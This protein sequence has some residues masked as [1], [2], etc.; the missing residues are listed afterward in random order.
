[1]RINIA[2]PLLDDEE[3][4]AVSRV[5]STGMIA[6]GPE[7][8]KFE[9]EFASYVGTKYACAVNNGTSALCLALSAAGISPGDEV[10]TTPFTFV[11][12]A[13]SILSCGAIPVFADIDEKTYNLCPKSVERLISE[14]TKAVMP[15]HLYGL[16]A[17]MNAFREIARS[18]GI[19]IIGD[20]AQAHGARIG[21]EMVG[22][23]A[24]MECFSFYPTKNMTT[25]EGGMVTTNDEELMSKLV[26][27][28]N[29]GRPTS[30]LTNYSHERFGLN[31]RLT[32]I[33]SAIG[34]VQLRKLPKFLKIR[35]RNAEILT[36]ILSKSQKIIIPTIPDDFQHAW[37]QYTIRVEDRS[38]VV[39]DLRIDGIGCGIYYPNLI[40][41]Y[42]HLK[43][44]YCECPNAEEIVKEVLSLPVHAGLSDEEVT[45]VGEAA[46]KSIGS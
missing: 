29:H 33:G 17:D 3:I 44:Y 5:I 43:K 9:Q 24:D 7:T 6:S 26:S 19:A 12:T 21:E 37:H 38:R 45:E 4:G 15:V 8:E 11:A 2:K 28:R 22:S 18:Y 41:E 23:L 34:R 13:N 39:N 46:I 30:K 25:G 31:L 35:E 32:D 27:I 20:A 40:F 10:I 1:M 14:K 16:P 36:N 42:P